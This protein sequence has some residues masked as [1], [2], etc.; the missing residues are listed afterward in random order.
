MSS[1]FDHMLDRVRD[2]AAVIEPGWGQGRAAFGGLMAALAY[3][4][5]AQSLAPAAPLRALSVSFVAP[6]TPGPARVQ[7]ELL[8]QGRSASQS[9]ARISQQDGVCTLI[10]ASHGAPRQSVI[11]IDAATAPALPGPGEGQV[12]PWLEGVVP[13]FTRHFELVFVQG[14]LPFSGEGRG[15]M[16]GWVRFREPPARIDIPHVLALLDAWPP[17]VLPMY[18]QP[19]PISS[20][21]WTMEWLPGAALSSPQGWWQYQAHTDVAADGYAQIGARL[22]NEQGELVVISRQT[23]ALFG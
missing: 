17:A 22:F 16:A 12:L 19:A 23:V 18:R 9:L 2:G 3:Q 7:A 8:R 1:A 21:A 11:A 20:L 6:G 14:G 4:G 10:Q 5:L 15:D 13:E